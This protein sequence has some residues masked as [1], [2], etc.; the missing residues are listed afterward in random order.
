MKRFVAFILSLGLVAMLLVVLLLGDQLAWRSQVLMLKARGELD[1]ITW[2]ETLRW[3]LPSSPVY[4][5]NLIEGRN[6]KR[7]KPLHKLKQRLIFFSSPLPK[8]NFQEI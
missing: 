5:S 4:L 3:M 6:L 1:F 8:I 2:S 7:P